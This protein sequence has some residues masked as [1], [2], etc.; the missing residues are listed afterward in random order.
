M[1]KTQQDNAGW[2]FDLGG[3]SALS[4][5]AGFAFFTLGPPDLLPFGA[6]VAA[7]LTFLA[8]YL[9]LKR[10]GDDPTDLPLS[11]F[12]PTEIEVQPEPEALLLDDILA[13]MGPNS[14]VVRLFAPNQMPTAGQLKQRIDQ[15]IGDARDSD[16]ADALHQALA[17]IRRSLR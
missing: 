2:L 14:R 5:A 12:A 8:A 6:A 13:S 3:A 10:I 17:D 15:H 7:S 1:S 16:A 9:L 4:G 11:E